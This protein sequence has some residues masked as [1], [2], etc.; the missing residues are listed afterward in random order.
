MS[1]WGGG[2]IR[3]TPGWVWRSRA[4]SA[5]PLCPGSWPPSPGLEPWAILICSSTALARYSGVTPKRPEA[6]CLIRELRSVV[7]RPR[8]AAPPGPVMA[9][10]RRLVGLGRE[11]A[12]AHGR[13]GEAAQHLRGRLD[14]VERGYRT[15]WDQ[16]QQARGG[17][18]GGRGG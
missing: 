5:D 13:G 12:V 17:G 18:G 6:T 16:V 1:W 9:P 8:V 11:R 14:L 15:G 10:R 2:E 4:I 3:A 7:K